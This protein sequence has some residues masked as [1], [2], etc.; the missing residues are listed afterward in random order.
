MEAECR[1]KS[2]WVGRSGALMLG[3]PGTYTEYTSDRVIIGNR[4]GALHWA[5]A[6]VFG[7][8]ALLLCWLL[9]DAPWVA[10]LFFVVFGVLPLLPLLCRM[11][12]EI[13]REGLQRRGKALGISQRRDWPLTADS[14]V[15]V[16][17]YQDRDSDNHGWTRHQTQIRVREGW[18]GVSESGNLESARDFAG[19]MA[20]A[21]GVPLF[22]QAGSK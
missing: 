22:G 9:R 17:T 15:R 20:A 10:G 19:R 5:I 2:E 12:Y 18:I 16:E 21:A 14:A 8:I 3:G 6:L 1:A 13:S 4:P 11:R 7:S